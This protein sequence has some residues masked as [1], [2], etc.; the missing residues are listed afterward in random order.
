M[1]KC[2]SSSW[3][4]ISLFCG[5]FSCHKQSFFQAVKIIRSLTFLVNQRF[6]KQG[7]R[8][9]HQASVKIAQ[10]GINLYKDIC[11]NVSTFEDKTSIDCARCSVRA[12]ILHHLLSA[13]SWLL[14]VYGVLYPGCRTHF[15]STDYIFVQESMLRAGDQR[16]YVKQETVQDYSFAFFSS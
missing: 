11:I 7:C 14:S 10:F 16:E 9:K 8:V 15:C 4:L 12:P 3:N 13:S 6:C 5:I 1:P 2:I